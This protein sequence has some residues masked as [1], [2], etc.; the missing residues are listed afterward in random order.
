M[1]SGLQMM[2]WPLICMPY[3]FRLQ[4][5]CKPHLDNLSYL[6]TIFSTSLFL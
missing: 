3:I 2:P 6:E 1:P 4:P 5:Y